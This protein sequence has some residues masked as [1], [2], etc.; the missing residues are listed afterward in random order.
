MIFYFFDDVYVFDLVW[1]DVDWCI[2]CGV[3]VDD[4][5]VVIW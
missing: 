5:E 3:V 1:F 4:F 2:V